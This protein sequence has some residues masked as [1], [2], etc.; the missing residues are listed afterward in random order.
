MMLKR[1]GL[2]GA[3]GLSL[4]GVPLA[5]APRRPTITLVYTT[6]ETTTSALVAWNTNIASDSLLQ[7]STGNPVSPDAPRVYRAAPVIVHEVELKGLT[8]GT[9]YYFRVTS[10]TRHGC[11]TATG[12]FDTYPSCPD[13]VPPASGSWQRS[14]TPN[15]GGATAVTNQL[16]AAAALSENDVWAVGWAQDP[17]GP[18]Y[19]R[20]TLIEHFDGTSWRIVPSPNRE[21]DHYNV[22]HAVSGTSA[23]DVWAVG[24]S[25]D[26]TLPSRTLIQHWDGTQWS[27]VASPSPGTQT[28]ELLGLAAISANDVWA[29]GSRSGVET[30]EPIDTLVLHWDGSDWSEVPSPNVAGGANQ[31]IGIAAIAANDIWAVGFAAGGP[32]AMHWNGSAWSLV[33]VERNAGSSSDWLTA[34]AGTAGTD[35]WAVGQG[36]GFYSNRAFATIRHWDG[37]HWTEKVCR[38]ASLSNPP[39]DYEGGGPDAYF[40]G[41]SAAFSHEV[42]AV[43]VL[44][45]GPRIFRWDGA[46]WTAVTHPRALPSSAVLR[47]VATS[48]GGGA[49]AVGGEFVAA[50]DGSFSPERT[51]IYRYIP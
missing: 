30:Q 32:L 3:L 20:R 19:V 15:V 9:L 10:C 35:V 17:N 14:L 49:W 46:A 34:V 40:T 31:L 37:V 7:Y 41:V 21:N 12:S 13:T 4:L 25:H 18:P 5:A 47:G 51:L 16:L 45:S 33:S 2:L 6:A 36:R 23:N 39:D 26:G 29:V 11:T 38:A 48:A 8:P 43:G 22:L 1:K 28:N 50:P 44:G 27:I 42:W 24:V